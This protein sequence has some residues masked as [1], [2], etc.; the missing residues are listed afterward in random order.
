[1]AAALTGGRRSP[2]ICGHMPG[3]L[4]QLSKWES[5]VGAALKSTESG[6]TDDVRTA[7]IAGHKELR[8]LMP[9][10]GND[11]ILTAIRG[12]H[13]GA[14]ALPTLTSSDAFF[15]DFLKNRYPQLHDG[16]DYESTCRWRS[17]LLML[18]AQAAA[19]RTLLTAA[20][21]GSNDAMTTTTA[22]N[23][24]P[25]V[26]APPA[27]M[28]ERNDEREDAAKLVLACEPGIRKQLSLPAITSSQAS[29]VARLRTLTDGLLI[30]RGDDKTMRGV[31]GL[32]RV[33]ASEPKDAD[34]P[35][36]LMIGGEK[37]AVPS[38]NFSKLP[39]R[40]EVRE[41]A[42]ESSLHVTAPTRAIEALLRLHPNDLL[43]VK[44]S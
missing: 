2:L 4:E 31:L 18:G 34:W 8:R 24:Q 3:T 27:K 13:R 9:D 20:G 22:V 5:H 38:R 23:F 17:V 12:A 1:M 6:R 28:K 35:A 40:T 32:N 14:F 11:N 39:G 41:F 37:H 21:K 16:N 25:L 26:K 36:E 42:W 7:M 15:L 30:G 44:F 33:D 19:I 43:S 10:G 29:V